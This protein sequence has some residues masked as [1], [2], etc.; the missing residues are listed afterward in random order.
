MEVKFKMKGYARWVTPRNDRLSNAREERK[1]RYGSLQP[2]NVY[3]LRVNGRPMCDQ[4]VELVVVNSNAGGRE[5]MVVPAGDPSIAGPCDIVTDGSAWEGKLALRCGLAFWMKPEHLLE[6]ELTGAVEQ[7][8]LDRVNDKI[9]A[10]ENN[11]VPVGFA[12]RRY[13]AQIRMLD[14][15]I[16]R[17]L[18]IVPGDRH[19]YEIPRKGIKRAKDLFK[20]PLFDDELP[21][22]P[23]QLAAV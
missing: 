5:W 18:T 1:Q 14:Q 20:K 6:M 2:G 10:I 4:K 17:L 22:M 8:Y 23:P 13:A 11:A 16:D 21:E 3:S 9:I 15:L 19:E 7:R 12:Q